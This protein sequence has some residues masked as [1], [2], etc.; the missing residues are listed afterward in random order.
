MPIFSSSVIAEFI[1]ED[2]PVPDAA[3]IKNNLDSVEP[4]QYG[5]VAYRELLQTE[6]NNNRPMIYV[7]YDTE[8]GHAWN[9]DGYSGEYFH[10]NWGWGGSQ[11]GYFLLSSLN[12]FNPVKRS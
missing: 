2:F 7:G 10:N 6:L 12:G 11:N 1:N 3:E 9:I 5:T 4:W 8:G